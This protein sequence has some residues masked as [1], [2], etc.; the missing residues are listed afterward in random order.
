VIFISKIRG[1]TL[2]ELLI[3]VA[4]MGILASVAYPSYVDFVLRSNRAEAQTELLRIA[5]LQEQYYLDQRTYASDMTKLG[6]GA[7][8]FINLNTGGNYNFDATVPA[9][10]E[11]FVLTATAIGTQLS[12]DTSCTTFTID[13]TGKKD[14]ESTYCWE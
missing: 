9:D 4:I 6:L 13:Q 10:G 11:S 1:V 3:A 14:A 8:P 7:D 2:I 12:K 5:N